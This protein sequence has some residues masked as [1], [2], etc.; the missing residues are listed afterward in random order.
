MGLVVSVFGLLAVIQ[1]EWAV[2]GLMAFI[3]VIVIIDRMTEAP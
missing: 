2:A 1:G 3:L